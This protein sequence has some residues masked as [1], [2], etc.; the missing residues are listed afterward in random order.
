M[1]YGLKYFGEVGDYYDDVY[2]VEIEEDGYTG[3]AAEM[4]MA[5][6]GPL[7]LSYPGDEF[8]VFRPILRQ[9]AFDNGYQHHQPAIHRNAHG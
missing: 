5:G 8:D 4:V 3:E 6:D 1:A 2:R 9:P 7:M